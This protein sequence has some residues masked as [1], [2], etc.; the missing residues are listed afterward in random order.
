MKKK[1]KRDKKDDKIELAIGGPIL[2]ARFTWG[3]LGAPLK[4]ENRF[5][6]LQIK[7]GEEILSCTIIWSRYGR[8]RSSVKVIASELGLRD[9]SFTPRFFYND[10]RSR[11]QI[12][13]IKAFMNAWH[14]SRGHITGIGQ[15]DFV[16]YPLPVELKSTCTGEV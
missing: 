9:F 14:G 4:R 15:D 13:M 7:V 1:K 16:P 6:L 2:A 10:K 3:A 5:G 11:W 8:R 12:D